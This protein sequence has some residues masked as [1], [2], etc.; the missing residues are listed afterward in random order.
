MGV[1]TYLT[2]RGGYAIFFGFVPGFQVVSSYFSY[3]WR[4]SNLMFGGVT[5]TF[6]EGYTF[7]ELFMK[8]LK[9]GLWGLGFCSAWERVWVDE[10]IELHTGMAPMAKP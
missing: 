9:T 5:P 3:K 10:Q 8:Y 6:G 2:T 1:L 4:L 7:Q